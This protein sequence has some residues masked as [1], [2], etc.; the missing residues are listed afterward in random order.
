MRYQYV[1]HVENQ[2]LNGYF[3][4][5]VVEV[6]QNVILVVVIISDIEAC[7]KCKKKEGWNWTGSNFGKDQNGHSI[8]KSCGAVFR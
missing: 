5:V 1:N 4:N 2:V 8:C 6:M 3:L 7:P